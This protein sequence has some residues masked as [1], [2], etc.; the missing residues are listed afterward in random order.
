MITKLQRRKVWLSFCG[1]SNI[2]YS[3]SNFIN[4]RT[5]CV[6]LHTAYCLA[7]NPTSW[8]N[9]VQLNKTKKI[10]KNYLS[11]SWQMFCKLHFG[12]VA[13]ADGFNQPI[14]SYVWLVCTAACWRS[15]PSIVIRHLQTSNKHMWWHLMLRLQMRLITSS[16]RHLT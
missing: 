7:I 9:N 4:A 11:P 6:C 16:L 12:K 10:Y 8:W 1:I 14:F 13:L 15:N 2:L 3:T 5:N